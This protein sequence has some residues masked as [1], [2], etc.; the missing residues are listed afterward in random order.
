MI[1]FSVEEVQKVKDFGEP[2]LKILCFKHMDTLKVYENITH[3]QF[4]YPDE[5]SV[6][7]STVSFA[8]LLNVLLSTGKYAV[9]RYVARKNATVRLV[10]LIPQREITEE[11]SMTVAEKK[12]LGHELTQSITQSLRTTDMSSHKSKHKPRQ[13][14]PPGFHIVPLPFSDDIRTVHVP[15]SPN[16]SDEQIEACTN[17]IK[18]TSIKLGAYDPA[19]YPNPM[20]QHVYSA[21][22]ARASKNAQPETFEDSTLPR[23]YGGNTAVINDANKA[24]FPREYDPDSGMAK[25]RKREATGAGSRARARAET[26]AMTDADWSVVGKDR[27]RLRKLKVDDLKKQGYALGFSGISKLKK[28]ELI[29]KL[30]DHYSTTQ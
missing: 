22:E 8:S 21:I 16:V 19:A 28:D 12:V 1:P 13:I 6:T 30:F 4:L 27:D 11:S 29:D 9:A 3:P 23:Q 2:S 18:K 17:M 25:T 26:T 14:M 5:D 20:L 10:A 24:L 15:Q 7:G